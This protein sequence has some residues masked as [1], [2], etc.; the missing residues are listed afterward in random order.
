MPKNTLI[1]LDE[2]FKEFLD[3]QVQSGRYNKASDVV[4]VELRLLE[5]HETRLKALQDALLLGQQSGE[6]KSFDSDAFLK[7]MHSKTVS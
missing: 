3:K 6:P 1:S 5:G 7:R 4:R 2:C